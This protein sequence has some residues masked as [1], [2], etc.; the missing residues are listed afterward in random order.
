LH[1]PILV[2]VNIGAVT[3]DMLIICDLIDAYEFD[4]KLNV[5][6]FSFLSLHV[7][8]FFYCFSDIELCKVLPE[9]ASFN[10]RVVQEVLNDKLHE[11]G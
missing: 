10:L 5:L 3:Y 8:H 1:D 4:S 9:F 11:F 7:H 6:V 2:T